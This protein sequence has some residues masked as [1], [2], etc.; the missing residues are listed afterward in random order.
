MMLF[1]HDK[2]NLLPG[3]WY[4]VYEDGSVVT[5]EEVEYWKKVQNKNKIKIVGLKCRSKRFELEDKD[6]YVPPGRTEMREISI[7]GSD[8]DEVRV[9]T[10]PTVGWFIGYYDNE[11]K[12]KV[13]VRASRKTGKF[14]KEEIPY[15]TEGD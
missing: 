7:S 5:V 11:K 13:I 3:G 9:T 2:I 10:V 14:Y 6:I 4:V 15:K 12:A 1:V 8:G